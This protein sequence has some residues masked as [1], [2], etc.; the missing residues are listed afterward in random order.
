MS[1]RKIL[2]KPHPFVLNKYSALL[3]A[4]ITFLVLV[5]LRPFEFGTSRIDRLLFW[6]FIIAIIVGL[7]VFI[8]SFAVKKYY[9]HSI[10]DKWTIKHEVLL[11]LFVL[12]LIAVEI[13]VLF[14]NLVSHTDRYELFNLV[15][16]RTVGI[17]FFPVLVLVL[18][19]Q[20]Q[21]QK[22]KRK[23]AERLNQKLL[24]SKSTD[25]KIKTAASNAERIVL[26]A[27]NKKV[28][29]KINPKDLVF[30]K[31]EGNYVEVFYSRNQETQ[32]E[33]IRISLKSI[34]EQLSEQDFFRCHNRFIVNILHIQKAEGNAR[35][36]ELSLFKI[37]EKIP[38]S[39]KKTDKLLELFQQRP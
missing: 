20:N 35:N 17:G 11:V 37:E 1:I 32:R 29:L 30:V 4:F 18:Y 8:S 6:S 19:E 5:I 2:Q 9:G 24:T 34:E 25:N 3:P 12:T 33:L 36:L 14:F 27:E 31:S 15:V 22:I 28:A 10:N 23:Q 38:V 7:T 26:L 16:L 39:R 21:H 13:Y